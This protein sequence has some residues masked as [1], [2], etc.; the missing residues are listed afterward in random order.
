MLASTAAAVAVLVAACGGGGDTT[1]DSP[2]GAAAPS[3]VAWA[4]GTITGFG[5]IIVNGVRYDDSQARVEKEDDSSSHSSSSLKLGMSVEVRSSSPDDSTGRASAS[6]IRFGSEI[7]GSISAVDATASTITV[8]GQVIDIKPNT[9]F[10][11]SLGGGFAALKVGQVVEVHALLDGTSGHYIATRIEDKPAATAFRL[12]GVVSNLSTSAKTFNIGAAVIS[13]ANVTP[14]NLASDLADGKRVRVL[15]Q[16]Q[17]ANGQWVATAVRTGVKRVDNIGDARLRGI[18]SALTSPQAFEVDGVRVDAS[19]AKFEPNPAAV[20]LGTRVEVKGKTVDG[21]LVA[22]KV[23]AESSSNS[24]D[25]RE[26]ELHGTVSALSTSAKTFVL[27]EVKVDYSAVTEWKDGAEA[28]LA[29]G[30]R[31][32]VKGEWSSDRR[33]LKAVRIEFES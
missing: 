5:S 19:N 25:W 22:T 27:R 20:T 6:E 26:T 18:V 12:R 16:P 21:V 24:R 23:E 7:V 8:L 11:D 31:V 1:T 28:N 29:D 13:Y 33:T 3:N 15:L 14:D 30:K 32:E 10:D 4:A 9:V 2:S 17:Q